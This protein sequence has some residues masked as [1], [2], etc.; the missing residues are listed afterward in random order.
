MFED[1]IIGERCFKNIEEIKV[2][3][4]SCRPKPKNRTKNVCIQPQLL[5][6]PRTHVN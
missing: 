5:E 4:F 1:A 2:K 3:Y 6:E